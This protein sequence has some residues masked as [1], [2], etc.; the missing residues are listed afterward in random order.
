MTD[1]K[2]IKKHE[3]S[4]GCLQKLIPEFDTSQNAQVY[5][6]IR[7]CDS[8][9]QLAAV[10]QTTAL[11][12]CAINKITGPGSSDV[13]AKQFT[14]WEDLKNFLIQKFSLGK[15]LAHL[16]L[17]LQSLFQKPQETVTQF[18][19]RVDL[20]RSKI[21][22]KLTTEI[23][24]RTLEGRK[25]TT[26]ETALSVFTNGINSDIGMMLRVRGFESLSDAG[27]FATQEEKIRNMNTARQQL[28]RNTP[29]ANTPRQIRQ[30]MSVQPRA[31]PQYTQGNI[32][33]NSPKTCN[34]CKK[35]GH[36]ITE[37]RKRAYNNSLKQPNLTH[38]PRAPL[39]QP[40]PIPSNTTRMVNNLNSQAAEELD[41][42][43][44]TA[45]NHV[46]N[47]QTPMSSSDMSHQMENLQLN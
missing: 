15:T 1:T 45:S 28:F 9:F 12:T 35:P 21:L 14:R 17:E 40:R 38:P 31:P 46:Y 22:E 41:M 33:P 23:K 16:N 2:D 42:Y 20:C 8:A 27:H 18:F 36:L 26:E 32:N 13:Y 25:A 44:E 6:F 34:Y 43:S 10:H 24:D 7:S 4:L 5:R 47:V 29:V 37:C 39:I 3:L 30:P 11:L 19:H